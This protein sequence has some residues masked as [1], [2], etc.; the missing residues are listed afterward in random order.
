VSAATPRISAQTIHPLAGLSY[1]SLD[2]VPRPMTQ[3]LRFSPPPRVVYRDYQLCNTPVFRIHSF[4]RHLLLI[5]SCHYSASVA[6]DHLPTC[7]W[8]KWV[9]SVSCGAKELL[10]RITVP[11]TITPRSLYSMLIRPTAAQSELMQG[12]TSP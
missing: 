2:S 7:S 3:Y 4:S 10:S 9:S 8:I 11:T 12:E 1:A 5:P 6:T